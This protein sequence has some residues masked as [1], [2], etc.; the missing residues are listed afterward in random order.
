MCVFLHT[1]I[2]KNTGHYAAGYARDAGLHIFT[3]ITRF[4][5][6]V[7][8]LE[9]RVGESVLVLFTRNRDSENKHKEGAMSLSP[10]RSGILRMLKDL[11][12]HELDLSRT[13]LLS[14]EHPVGQAD[15][16]LLSWSFNLPLGRGGLDLDAYEHNKCIRAISELFRLHESGSASS[17]SSCRTVG[18]WVGLIHQSL[19]NNPSDLAF[20]DAAEDEDYYLHRLA[21]LMA[22][23]EALADLHHGS[24][25]IVCLLPAHTL[26]GYLYGVLL[27][28]RLGV[29]VVDARRLEIATFAQ[30]LRRR[31]LIV[32]EPQSWHQ[33]SRVMTSFPDNCAGVVANGIIP[34]QLM[35]TLVAFGVDPIQELYS[36]SELGC[37]AV[38]TFPHRT[39]D[40]LPHWKDTPKGELERLTDGYT[41]HLP[42]GLTWR[43]DRCFEMDG[44]ASEAVTHIGGV[45]V[46]LLAIAERLRHLDE[47]K[48]CTLFLNTNEETPQLTASIVLAE[49]AR[50]PD[51]MKA[52]LHTWCRD[53]LPIME[54]PTDF[55]INGCTNGHTATENIRNFNAA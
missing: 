53:N 15:R 42:H 13:V 37:V 21:N 55:I 47:I 12:A 50:N 54:R 8:F 7:Y 46:S 2:T 28:E 40:L 24:R 38:R 33:L 45:R 14:G 30:L 6:F 22:E 5:V 25:R 32:A 4:L 9:R 41:T 10:S 52:Y 35:M 17:L 11:V 18:E 20:K 34:A 39:Y 48:D 26:M 27:P 3:P 19:Q 23:V 1:E 44:L 43:A 51:S 36:P 16:R 49:G 29:P 31:D